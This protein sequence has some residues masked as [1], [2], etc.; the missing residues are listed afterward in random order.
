MGAFG[1]LASVDEIVEDDT[2]FQ[3]GARQYS[4]VV[5]QVY[6]WSAHNQSGVREIESEY[7]MCPGRVRLRQ[8]QLPHQHL[9]CQPQARPRKRQG[10][11]DHESHRRCA[12]LHLSLLPHLNL[13]FLL[14]SNLIAAAL[15]WPGEPLH[16]DT[17]L[18]SDQMAS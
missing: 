9:P 14:R 6:S 12:Q 4:F 17:W 3:A 7:L 13:L 16:A 18:A 1:Q 8:P 2:G 5:V 11:R 15:I 10:R